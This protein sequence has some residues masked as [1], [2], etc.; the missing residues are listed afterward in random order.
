[1][2][3]VYKKLKKERGE[4]VALEAYAQ[5]MRTRIIPLDQDSALLAADTSLTHSLALADAIVYSTA[6]THSAE[7]VTSDSH[8]QGLDGTRFVK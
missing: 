7:H 4:E 5:I 1:M 3:E 8:L 6:K 2:Y